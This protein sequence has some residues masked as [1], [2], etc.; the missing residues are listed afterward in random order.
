[1]RITNCS[2]VITRPVFFRNRPRGAPADSYQMVV[3]Q[4]V[5]IDTGASTTLISR[6]L[7]QLLSLEVTA[8]SEVAYANSSEERCD[9]CIIHM[10]FGDGTGIDHLEVLILP[11]ALFEIEK[12][13]FVVEYKYDNSTYLL[14]RNSDRKN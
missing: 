4:P 9:K 1:M 7:Q 2:S 10:E 11:S 5:I 3:M 12:L 6:E 14:G 8:T 13:N